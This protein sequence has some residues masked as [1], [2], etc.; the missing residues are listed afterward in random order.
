M[1]EI[2][3]PRQQPQLR[4][5]CEK[6]RVDATRSQRLVIAGEGESQT[7]DTKVVSTKLYGNLQRRDLG[8]VHMWGHHSWTHVMSD[9][10]VIAYAIPIAPDKTRVR[11]VWL[12][13]GDA[14]ECVDYDLKK[15]TEVW[16][17]T[18]TQDAELVGNTHSGTQDPGYVPGPY[19]KYTEG[20]L[21]QFAR[22][23]D[24][25]LRASGV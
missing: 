10:A 2:R 4:E 17:A 11:T 7:L 20:E 8:N 19:S 13:N 21:E 3:E 12:V 5:G 15:L 24:A 22:W 6:Q 25:R 9:H 1:L 18:T 14:V 23:Y 16:V